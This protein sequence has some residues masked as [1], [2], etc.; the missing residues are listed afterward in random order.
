MLKVRCRNLSVR[1]GIEHAART[2]FIEIKTAL[3]PDRTINGCM[4]GEDGEDGEDGMI[5]ADYSRYTG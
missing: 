5:D 4:Y 1:H 3:D 2:A